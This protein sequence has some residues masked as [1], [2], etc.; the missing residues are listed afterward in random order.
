M[1]LA[2]SGGVITGALAWLLWPHF[3]SF[4]IMY[5]S[6]FYLHNI[7]DDDDLY[8]TFQRIRDQ[9]ITS[10]NSEDLFS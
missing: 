2:W 6:L 5:F 4:I 3:P 8:P 7:N 10:A 9:N 1:D